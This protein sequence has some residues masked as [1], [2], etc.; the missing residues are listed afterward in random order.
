MV[1]KKTFTIGIL[2]LSAVILLVANLLAPRPTSAAY[3]TEHD[4]DYTMVIAPSTNGD[5]VYLTEKRSGKMAAVTFNVGRRTLVLQDA[6]PVQNAFAK[7]LR[8]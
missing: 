8:H 2:S 4:N 3:E 5:V 7:L 6:Q 1:D